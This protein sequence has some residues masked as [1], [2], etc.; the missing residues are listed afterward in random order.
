MVCHCGAANLTLGQPYLKGTQLFANSDILS[1]RRYFE[2]I[3]CPAVHQFT[4]LHVAKRLEDNTAKEYTEVRKE[5][6]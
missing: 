5:L 4:T 6:E 3:L 2:K 1:K